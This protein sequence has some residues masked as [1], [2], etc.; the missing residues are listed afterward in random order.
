MSR[1]SKE[2]IE[3]A[4]ALPDDDRAMLAGLLIESLDAGTESEVEEEWLAE[5]ARR[6][7]AIERGEVDTIPW[8]EVRAKLFAK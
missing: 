6:W 5:A 4:I 7:G 8:E 2:I 3:E 1:N